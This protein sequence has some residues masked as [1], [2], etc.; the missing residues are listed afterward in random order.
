LRRRRLV[1]GAVGLIG[2]PAFAAIVV[3]KSAWEVLLQEVSSDHNVKWQRDANGNLV[4]TGNNAPD[5]SYKPVISNPQS[6][7]S[8]DSAPSLPVGVAGLNSEIAG[9]WDITLDD[10][11]DDDARLRVAAHILSDG[12][13]SYHCVSF[14]YGRDGS[15]GDC[16]G[17]DYSPAADSNEHLMF[18]LNLGPP[19]GKGQCETE[20]FEPFRKLD[21]YSPDRYRPIKFA[22]VGSGR[23]EDHQE[24]SVSCIPS[25]DERYMQT[26]LVQV[27]GNSLR[28]SFTDEPVP[29]HCKDE[30]GTFTRVISG[31][32]ILPIPR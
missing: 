25:W 12:A 32:R 6:L 27:V 21:T 5:Q 3:P 19:P 15:K 9:D 11:L 20:P 1:L 17:K 30:C 14:M 28:G 29:G 16:E 18:A 7:V 26:I 4:A 8:P 10:P 22:G 31:N 24:H 13:V 23:Y 2:I